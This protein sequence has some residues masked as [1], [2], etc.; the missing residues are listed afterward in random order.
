M[1]SIVSND[2]LHNSLELA[3]SKLVEPLKVCLFNLNPLPSD[4][5]FATLF[6]GSGGFFLASPPGNFTQELN[7]I[8]EKMIVVVNLNS[9]R[10]IMLVNFKK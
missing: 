2:A 3:N 8:R 5:F 10:C 4:K 7:I 9:F 1:K 6:L